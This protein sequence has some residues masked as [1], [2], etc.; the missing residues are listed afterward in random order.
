[1]SASVKK[2]SILDRFLMSVTVKTIFAT[3]NSVNNVVS[4]L[5]ANTNKAS[6]MP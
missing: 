1:M 3:S 2:L 5:F 6:I 4:S